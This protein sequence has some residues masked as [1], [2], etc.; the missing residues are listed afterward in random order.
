MKFV[1]PIVSILFAS[2]FS[3]GAVVDKSTTP[4][5]FNIALTTELMT[6][7]SL[8]TMNTPAY[9]NEELALFTFIMAT[10]QVS[11]RATQTLYD[12]CFLVFFSLTYGLCFYLDS[13]H[14]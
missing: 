7:G 6:D 14:L 3:S 13:G 10:K 11:Y 12:T 4:M 8:T 2:P 5:P 9:A 1:A